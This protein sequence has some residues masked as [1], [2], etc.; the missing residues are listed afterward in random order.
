MEVF[1]E[2]GEGGKSLSK[3]A[4]SADPMG[5]LEDEFPPETV[6]LRFCSSGFSRFFS[7]SHKK[8]KEE[9]GS[10]LTLAVK[11]AKAH[12]TSCRVNRPMDPK[13]V[14]AGRGLCSFPS[15]GMCL[16]HRDC[17]LHLGIHWVPWLLP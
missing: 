17:Q 3:D 2:K 4:F 9:P 12:K 8:E 1:Q 11:R 5:A 14:T 10:S 15:L 13:R 6:P 16:Q 7:R